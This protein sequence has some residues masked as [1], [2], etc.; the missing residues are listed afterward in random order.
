M[1]NCVFID[2]FVKRLRQLSQGMYKKVTYI[3][4]H[5]F[6]IQKRKSLFIPMKVQLITI[7]SVIPY[8]SEI[9]SKSSSLKK[10]TERERERER[11]EEIVRKERKKRWKREG[12]GEGEGKRGRESAKERRKR[13]KRKKRRK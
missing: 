4:M 5:K 7:S 11:E 13:N 2:Y 10:K 1:T 6:M 8:I 12:E 9:N 3:R